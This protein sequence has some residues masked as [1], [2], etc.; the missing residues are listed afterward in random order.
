MMVCFVTFFIPG[1]GD[2]PCAKVMREKFFAELM[3]D[4]RP[5]SSKEITFLLPAQRAEISA[6][7]VLAKTSMR[8]LYRH[9]RNYVF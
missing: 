7:P 1:A 2:I 3:A 9:N 4:P 5:G 6:R 8:P